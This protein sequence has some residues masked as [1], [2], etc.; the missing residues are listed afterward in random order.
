LA[1]VQRDMARCRRVLMQL[2]H[3]PEGEQG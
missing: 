1:R 3:D 2:G